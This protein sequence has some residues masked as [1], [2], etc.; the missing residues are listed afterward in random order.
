M[1]NDKYSPNDFREEELF[2]EFLEKHNIQNN[3]FSPLIDSSDEIFELEEINEADKYDDEIKTLSDIL[4]DSLD[5]KEENVRRISCLLILG[6]LTLMLCINILL[7]SKDISEKENR[8]LAQFP[9]ISMKAIKDGSF[10][11]GFEDYISDQ[12]AFRNS[13]V[14]AKRMT[15]VLIGK[16][17]NHDILFGKDGYL[18]ENSAN[19]SFSNVRSNLKAI[20]DLAAVKRY[21]I[22]LAVVPTAYEI[23]QNKLPRN[24][25]TDVYN[26]LNDTIKANIKEKNIQIADTYSLLKENSDQYLYYRS[27]HHQTAHGSYYL[28]S[29]LAKNLSYDAIAKDK[30]KIEA[31][32]DDFLGTMWSNSGFANT[33][34]D[35]IY[36]YT[37]KDGYTHKV[38]F[39]AE[40]KTMNSLYSDNML[41]TKDKYAYYLDGNHGLAEI[42]TN[43]GG[44]KRI[45]IIKDSYAHSLVPFLAN[46]YSKIYMIDLR[47]YNGDIFEYLY[48]SRIND[49]LIIYN[50]NTFMTDTNLSKISAFAKTSSY[51]TVPDVNYG[52]VPEL[53]KVD[54]TYFDDAVFVG[55]SLTLGLSYFSG[56]NAD[57]LCMGGLSTKNLDTEPVENGKTV[58]DTIVSKE[59][60]GKI[61]IMLGTNESI[62]QKPDEFTERYSSFIDKVRQHHPDAV[63]YIL[64]IMPISKNFSETHDLKNNFIT[65]HNKYLLQLAKEKQCYY[66]DVNSFF[67]GEDGYLPDNAGGDGVHLSPENYRLMADY[68]KEH[69]VRVGG[70]KKIG[71]SSAKVFKGGK[72]DTAKIAEAVVGKVKF[73][74]TL[75]R[76]S[77]SLIV[78]NYGIDTKH[79][80]SAALY[81]GG[82]S[83]AEEVA[84]FETDSKKSTDAVV[85]CIKKRIE[86]KKKDFENYIPAEMSKLNNPYV[87]RK[88][89]IV[90]LCLAD[91]ADEEVI[92]ACI[93]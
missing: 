92:K 23:M 51:T 61:Y 26:R 59:K 78:S 82:G 9:R 60:I 10:S 56:F 67:A 33:K 11:K 49:V 75:S 90:V 70:V 29:A 81:V 87:V 74:D 35:T 69:A 34:E 93:K 8:A 27:D 30:F 52:I 71:S 37:L 36:K 72:S 55:D 31:K 80:L 65:D 77:D 1:M 83:T 43:C 16:K 14:S 50:Q 48:K 15:E 64:S 86:N 45:A 58:I 5:S 6:F 42:E 46:H 7:P 13:F 2:K 57:F 91:S 12:F 85:K 68:L 28:Y 21:N 38:T 24:A 20:E 22:T 47:Y 18:I 84:V 63:V 76:V 3:A 40:K 53:E 44:D 88:G 17:E 66:I 73:K 19:L 25:Y 4:P 41:K 54:N 32:A 79:V 39:P 62:Y 89:N